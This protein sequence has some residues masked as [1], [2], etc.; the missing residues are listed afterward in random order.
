MFPIRY[1]RVN[2][3]Q[4]SNFSAFIR[5]CDFVLLRVDS[6]PSISETIVEYFDAEYPGKFAFGTLDKNSIPTTVWWEKH[7]S[8]RANNGISANSDRWSGWYLF[9]GGAIVGRYD[10][11]GLVDPDLT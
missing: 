4:L 8:S 1:S 9:H 11:K 2:K 5:S 7:F 6:L 3:V 10:P